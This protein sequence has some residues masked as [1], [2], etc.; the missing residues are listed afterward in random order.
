MLKHALAALAV[1][2]L[3]VST[4]ILA[5]TPAQADVNVYTTP[6]RHVVNGRQWNTTCSAYDATI[7]RCRA[8]IMSGGK[9]V[10]NNLTYLPVD[11]IHWFDDPLARPG[12]F[13][14]GG[15][16]WITSCNDDWT[17]KSACRTFIW[18]ANKWVFNNLVYFTP[19]D[20]QYPEFTFNQA[21][22][23][24]TATANELTRFWLLENTPLYTNATGTASKGNIGKG[25]ATIITQREIGDRSEIF[26]KGVF[27]F[28]PTYALSREGVE[29][30][31]T[32]EDEGTLNK[33]SSSGL[34]KVNDNTKKVI[35][36]V[37]ANYPEITTMYG[38]SKRTTP[39]HP[40]G[41]AVDVMI[42]NWSKNKALGWEIA[43]YFRANADKFGVSYIIF[44]QHIWSVAR[45]SQGWR[46]MDDRGSNT[47]N[48]LDHVHVNTYDV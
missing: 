40:A 30:P 13:T 26:H 19:G 47:A 17:G 46:A 3:T 10:F 45:D 27:A 37:W 48:H 34:D 4:A 33:G 22:G 44:D 28:V 29:P 11:R 18:S 2:A 9:W 23:N 12:K 8:E 24:L 25:T 41:R 42:P 38:W 20:V 14:S 5:P 16:E 7:T 1:A 36:H 35:R 39:D 31:P 21:T 6:G 32:P 43:R 15:R